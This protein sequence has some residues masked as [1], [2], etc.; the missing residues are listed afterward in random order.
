M[1]RILITLL[2][3][4]SL[5]LAA[6]AWAG[7][8]APDALRLGPPESIKASKAMVDFPHGSHVSEG[9]DCTT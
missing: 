8:A 1:R 7:P 2:A 9:T 4:C 5:G 3:L 6:T